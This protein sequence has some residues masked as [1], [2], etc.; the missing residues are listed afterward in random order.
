MLLKQIANRTDYTAAEKNIAKYILENANLIERMTIQELAQKTFT[1]HTSIIRFAQK[2]GMKGF[3]DFKI[4]LVKSI[5]QKNHVLSEIN[6]NIP[7]EDDAS[8][9]KISQDMMYLTQQTI[10]ESYELLKEESL[11]KMT[12]YLYN[13]NRIFMYAVGDSQIRAESFQNKLL[14]INKYAI[15]ATA[16]NEFANNT[17]N[18]DIN[19]CAFFITYEAKSN[20]DFIAARI[21]KERKVP[22]LL[23]TAFPESKLAKM[24]DVVLTIPALEKKE[25]D[26]IATFASQVSIDYV[27]NVLFSSLYQINYTQNREHQRKSTELIDRFSF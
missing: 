16:R 21:L 11:F 4:M 18:I 5:E 26:K 20:E 15:I 13:A 22:I 12:K 6:P 23:L 14:K 9:M 10:K 25:T 8:L 24:A 3:K 7:F 1:S 17:V 19:D 27:L 2:L